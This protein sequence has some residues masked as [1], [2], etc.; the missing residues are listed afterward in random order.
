M[1]R[2]STPIDPADLA[3]ID[4]P[5]LVVL[6]DQDFVGPADELLAAL[7]NARFVPLR[8]CDHFGTPKDFRFIDAALSFLRN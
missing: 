2:A 4:L 3:R 5:V 6:G 1:R 8:G 7:P